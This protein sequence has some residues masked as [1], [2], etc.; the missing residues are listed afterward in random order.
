[1]Q[2]AVEYAKPKFLV[3][4][5]GHKKAV[6]INIKEY[7]NIL[8]LIEDLEDANDLLRAENEATTFTPYE[9]FRRKWLKN[10]L[11]PTSSV[12]VYYKG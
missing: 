9:K 6:M 7:E 2:S 8:E 1:M 3:D 10:K 4:A 11:P 12:V 5:R